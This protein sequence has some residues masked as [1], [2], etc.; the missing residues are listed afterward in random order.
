[1]TSTE[2]EPDTQL[3]T[4]HLFVIADDDVLDYHLVHKAQELIIGYLGGQ[5]NSGYCAR[6]SKNNSVC[7]FPAHTLHVQCIAS[8]QFFSLSK[9]GRSKSSQAEIPEQRMQTVWCQQT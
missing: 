3:V 5:L 1:M 6:N 9:A 2:D 4:E 8:S 7:I